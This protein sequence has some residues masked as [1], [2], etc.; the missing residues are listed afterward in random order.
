MALMISIILTAWKEERTV[1]KAVEMLL[2]QVSELADSVELM[3]VCPDKGTHDSA[4]EAVDKA[5]FE[6]FV[7]IKDPQ[8]GKPHAMN[9]VLEKA[10]GEIIISTDGDVCIEEG[11]LKELLRPFSEKSVGGVT[12]RPM[13][14]NDRKTMWGYWGHMFMDAAHKKRVE[15]LSN[16]AFFVMSGYLLAFRNVGINIPNGVLDDV[17]ISYE[18]NRQ[19]YKIA[20][21]KDAKVRV[22]QPT[23]NHDWIAQKK[24]SVAGHSGLSKYIDEVPVTRSFM[25]DLEYVLFPIQYARNVREFLWSIMQ[26]PYR[27]YIW[28]AAGYEMN[29]RK[30][31]S[32]EIWER[33][34]STK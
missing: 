7:Y 3:L 24:R 11:A 8:K 13:C 30:R 33:T 27:L 6:N 18:L 1:G 26:Y 23:N 34:K 14:T 2:G 10:K 17:Y 4:R 19:G 22:Q 12:G 29:V 28:V 16:G 32:T 21:A 31:T 9:L 15:T 5:S 20:Y 25:K